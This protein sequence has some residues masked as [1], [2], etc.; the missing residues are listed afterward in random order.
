MHWLRAIVSSRKPAIY[1]S[2]PSHCLRRVQH[3]LCSRIWASKLHSDQ[4]LPG[5]LRQKHKKTSRRPK[6]LL[7]LRFKE[8]REALKKNSKTGLRKTWRAH[9][10]KRLTIRERR[11]WSSIRLA[12]TQIISHTRVTTQKTRKRRDS[13]NGTTLNLIGLQ[14]FQLQRCTKARPF[15]VTSTQRSAWK[16]REAESSQFQMSALATSLSW[17]CSSP[18]LKLRWPLLRA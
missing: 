14:S 11:E 1:C 9:S 5:K 12:T 3:P 2:A 13:L 4:N 18:F 8:P 7:S 15:W 6:L 17:V 10:P 16:S